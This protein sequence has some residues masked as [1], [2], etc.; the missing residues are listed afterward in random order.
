M[1]IVLKS[2][3]LKL[4][5]ALEP[6]QICNGI[7]L[8]HHIYQALCV[9]YSGTVK[10]QVAEDVLLSTYCMVSGFDVAKRWILPKSHILRI[11]RGEIL[12]CM[13]CGVFEFEMKLIY[14]LSFK[15]VSLDV[16]NNTRSL[17]VHNH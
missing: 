2:G 9:A 5:E 1:P 11:P 16:T 6:V 4:L 3:S 10:A 13:L 8:H 7:A 14:Q 15:Y 12:V 17:P